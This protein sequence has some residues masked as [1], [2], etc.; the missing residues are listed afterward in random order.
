MAKSNRWVFLSEVE[1]S[2][3]TSSVS[4]AGNHAKKLGGSSMFAFLARRRRT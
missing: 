3:S 4:Q 2:G 1:F